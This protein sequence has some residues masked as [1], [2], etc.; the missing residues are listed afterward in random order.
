MKG[1]KNARSPASGWQ[2]EEKEHSAP[3]I[4]GL[5][6]LQTDLAFQ[7]LLALPELFLGLRESSLSLSELL[8]GLVPLPDCLIDLLLARFNCRDCLLVGLKHE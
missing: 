3:A 1:G 8:P 2:R 5:S 7:L 6:R 4:C